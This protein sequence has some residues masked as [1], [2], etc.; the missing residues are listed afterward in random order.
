M[1]QIPLFR[2]TIFGVDF[3]LLFYYESPQLVLFARRRWGEYNEIHDPH[4]TYKR[5]HGRKKMIGAILA[6]RA[7]RSGFAALE[8]RDIDQFVAA[9]IDDAA[10]IYPGDLSV[11]GRV[12]GKQAIKEW[13]QRFLEQFPEFHFTLKSVCVENIFDLIGTNVVAVEWDI[14]LTNREGTT[15]QNSGVTTIHT[16]KGKGVLV[17]DYYSDHVALREGWGEA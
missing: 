3:R 17:R 16:E 4:F 14:S 13:F 2:N 5:T 10:F 6:K 11:S 12:E 8:R 7:V 1:L 15:L 9:W